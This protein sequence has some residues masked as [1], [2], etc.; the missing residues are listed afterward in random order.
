MNFNGDL[1]TKHAYGL[2][3]TQHR[4]LASRTRRG[5]CLLE[6][7]TGGFILIVFGLACAD[8]AWLMLGS[9]IC[10]DLA[11][12]SARAAANAPNMQSAQAAVNDIVSKYNSPI[13]FQS[14]S[15]TLQRYDNTPDGILTI[16][17]SANV[18]LLV[19]IPLIGVG[20]KIPIQTQHSEPIVGIA[21]GSSYL[22]SSN[23]AIHR[24]FNLP[25]YLRVGTQA[26]VKRQVI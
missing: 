16:V 24:I 3:T 10:T 11:K 14:L 20:T 5:Q 17:C 22:T 7:I 13:A 19:P 8:V 1:R 6:A 21:P 2:S 15:L 4:K 25:A 12:Q 23:Q 18:S 26:M 9:E